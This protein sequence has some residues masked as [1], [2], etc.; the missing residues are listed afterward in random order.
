MK[1]EKIVRETEKAVLVT[2]EVEN[3]A[4]RRAVDFWFPRSQITI[5]DGVLDAPDWLV[6]AKLIEK[7]GDH[8]GRASWIN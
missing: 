8:I 5:T 7:F 1:I 4:G 2:V 3:G 6:R